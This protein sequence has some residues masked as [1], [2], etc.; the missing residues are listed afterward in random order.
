MLNMMELAEPL[1]SQESSPYVVVALQE[2]QRMNVL[3]TE[4]R[5]SL[6]ELD[7][8]M[9]CRYFLP[10]LIPLLLLSLQHGESSLIL[11][12]AMN[13]QLDPPP[14]LFQSTSLFPLNPLYLP[15]LS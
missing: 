5:R 6:V 4:V 11:S 12:L 15:P 3:L 13:S 10:S 1:L 7:K 14:C 2:C 8:G 9:L